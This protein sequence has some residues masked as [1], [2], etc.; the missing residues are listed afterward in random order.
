VSSAEEYLDQLRQALPLGYRRRLTAEVREH[1]ASAVAAETERGLQVDEAVRL[2]I[3]RLGPPRALAEELRR[4]LRSGALGAVQRLAAAVTTARGAVVATSVVVAFVVAAGLVSVRSSSGGPTLRQA[5]ARNA[6]SAVGSAYAWGH[7]SRAKGFDAG[8]LVVWAYARAGAA[9][10]PRSADALWHL[11]THVAP[12]H[13]QPGDLLF[14]DEHEL[15]GIYVGDDR[16]VDAEHTGG[17]VG[18]HR[19]GAPGARYDGAVR[20]RL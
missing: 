9:P 15:V 14:F 16:F 2:T 20:V 8:G 13:L 5:A 6:L 10:L 18:I 7:A 1:F 11:G 19:L 17:R 12:K 3:E 4:D